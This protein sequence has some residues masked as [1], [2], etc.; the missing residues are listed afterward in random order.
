V[1]TTETLLEARS[2]G[3]LADDPKLWR[4]K[5][6]L[7]GLYAKAGDKEKADHS[8][9]EIAKYWRHRS[10]SDASDLVP[11]LIAL[12]KVAAETRDLRQTQAMAEEALTAAKRAGKGHEL[13]VAQAEDNL[14]D[15]LSSQKHVKDA[16]R[17]YRQAV[18]ICLTLPS[19]RHVDAVLCGS[20]LDLAKIYKAHHQYG[21][22]ADFCLMAL[23]VRKKAPDQ[24]PQALVGLYTATATLQL[25]EA[26]E[27]KPGG[28]SDP[29]TQAEANIAAARRLCAEH[30][31]SDQTAGINVLE[32][33]AVLEVR[34]DHLDAARKTLGRALTLSRRSH[35]DK[36][37]AKIETQIA[38]LD[39][40]EKPD[41]VKQ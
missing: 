31:W 35:L 22:A 33:E 25:A 5:G 20:L 23:D 38:Q 7:A 27:K 8:L 24:D 36:L 13:L 37:E 18:Q 11:N 14:A 29:L 9:D 4:L 26:R 2:H 16:I 34:R 28:G 19:D 15:L 12:S 40:G 17:H 10:P 1:T 3:L 32:L 39:R 6:S 41:T 21:R 30:G